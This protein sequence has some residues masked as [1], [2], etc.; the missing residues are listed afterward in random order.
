MRCCVEVVA[1]GG[2]FVDPEDSSGLHHNPPARVGVVRHVQYY[3]SVFTDMSNT[4]YGS[5][6]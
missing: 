5:A 1:V 4:F 2:V 3:A 6:C